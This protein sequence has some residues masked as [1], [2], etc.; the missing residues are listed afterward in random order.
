MNTFNFKSTLEQAKH[1]LMQQDFI[2]VLQHFHFKNENVISYNDVQACQLKLKTGLNCTIPGQLLLKLLNTIKT[3]EVEIR[4]LPQ[5]NIVELISGRN[6]SKLPRS[7]SEDY[8][9]ELPQF[10]GDKLN[11]QLGFAFITTNSAYCVL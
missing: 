2:A 6:K 5:Q 4:E 1:F 11:T 7:P 10:D 3:D 9:F 8:V